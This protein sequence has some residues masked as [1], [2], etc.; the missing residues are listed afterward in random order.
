V[1]LRSAAV[2]VKALTVR[3]PHAS[4]I[5]V[6]TKDVE[7]RSWPTSHR[8][9]LAIHAGLRDDPL[10][11]VDPDLPH[12]MLLGT[13]ILID[14]VRNHPSPSALPDLWHW[15]LADPRPCEPLRAKGRQGLW[16]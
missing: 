13:V 7:N 10:E 12:G 8:G 16:T 1:R 11:E 5:I 9:L 3:Q 6:G 4:R 15:V 2:D 14:C